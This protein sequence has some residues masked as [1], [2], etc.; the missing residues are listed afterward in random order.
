MRYDGAYY[1]GES[2]PR[3]DWQSGGDARLWNLNV[4]YVK[5]KLYITLAAFQTS[6]PRHEFNKLQL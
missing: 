3:R 4:V 6:S 5:K 2:A 1:D